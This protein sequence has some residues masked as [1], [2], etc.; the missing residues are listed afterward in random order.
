ML[1]TVQSLYAEKDWYTI[2]SE[3]WKVALATALPSVQCTSPRPISDEGEEY[4]WTSFPSKL[5][6]L[7]F[8][9]F[10]TQWA[11]LSILEI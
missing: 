6:I 11:S 1:L 7:L 5:Y 4:A 2:L 3:G 9:F 8:M 10:R